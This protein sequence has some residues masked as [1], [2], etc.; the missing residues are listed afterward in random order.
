MNITNEQEE[1]TRKLTIFDVLVKTIELVK[2]NPND[3]T[4]GEKVRELI[5]KNVV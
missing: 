5:N 1:G 4:L 2:D 3:Q